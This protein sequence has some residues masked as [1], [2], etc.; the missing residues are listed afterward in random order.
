[1]SKKQDLM[2]VHMHGHNEAGWHTWTMGGA[3]PQPTSPCLAYT[4]A[5]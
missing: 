2:A 1:M 4:M 3:L 5:R